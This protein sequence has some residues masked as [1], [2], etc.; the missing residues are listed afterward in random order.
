MRD[1]PTAP[2]A[3]FSFVAILVALL[4]AAA[5]YFGYFRFQSSM[6]GERTKGIQSIAAAKDVACR[7]QRQQIE[8]DLQLYSADHD[9]PAR[10]LDDLRH[11]GISVPGC[12]EG[13]EYRLSGTRVVCSKHQ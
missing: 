9:Q 5:L 3:G 4:V 10:S 13:G 8:R 7:T 2:Q 6:S 12:P 1:R 11:A